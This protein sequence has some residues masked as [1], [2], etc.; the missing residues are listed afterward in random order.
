MNESYLIP[1]YIPF[2]I[3]QILI[4][5]IIYLPS[6]K[7]NSHP[8]NL[9]IILIILT[10]L[11]CIKINFITKSWTPYILFLTQ[12]GGLFIILIYIIS[13][14][15]NNFTKLNLNDIILTIIKLITFTILLIITPWIIYN[16]LNTSKNLIFNYYNI[17]INN[18]FNHNF[19]LNI[20]IIIYLLL[21]II[22]IINICNKYKSPFRQLYLYE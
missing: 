2:L 7:I 14:T 3:S 15:N 20:F 1:N 22:C 6:K 18:L 13:L 5:L 8:I 4:I 21:S 10:I 16:P 11:I 19:I 12:I 9:I 17:N